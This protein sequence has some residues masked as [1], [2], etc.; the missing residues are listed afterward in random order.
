MVQIARLGAEHVEQV[1][2]LVNG[3]LGAAIPGWELPADYFVGRLERNPDEYVEDLWVAERASFVA[4]MEGRACAAAHVLRFRDHTP[5]AETGEIAWIVAWP[6]APEAGA[7]VL[8]AASDQL[9]RWGAR[10]QI[11]YQSLFVPTFAGV[12]DVWPH[13]E[14]L[15]RDAGFAPD[16]GMD[17]AIYA[18]ALR[19]APIPEPPPI[20][21]L[22]IMRRAGDY[23]TCIE[24]VLGGRAIC[25]CEFRTD[26]GLGGALPAFDGWAELAQLEAEA[27]FRGRRVGSWVVSHM[28]E[29]LRQGGFTKIV[30]SVGA[31][32]EAAGA[33]RF[34]ER[35]GWSPVVRLRRGWELAE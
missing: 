25:E 6:G 1:M 7:A 20:D 14:G 18:G 35:F 34:Y 9:C 2:R 3:H 33:G 4:L 10:R 26:L 24:A 30:L 12:P 16:H 11:V 19:E 32:D 28:V 8:A 29:Y 27:S 31:D 5:S 17:E 13:V 21:G 22:A 15:L 23:G